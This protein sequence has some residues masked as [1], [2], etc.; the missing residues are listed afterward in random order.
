MTRYGM[1]LIQERTA[2]V[3]RLQKT[4]EG[5]NIK[6]ASVAS[7]VLGNSGREMREGL[8]GGTTE[9]TA[10]AELAKGKLRKKL[11]ELQRAL[12]GRF[13]PHQRFLLGLHLARIA[14]LDEV[15]A[16]LDAE[17]AERLH[18][19]AEEIARLDA[20]PSVAWRTA[21]V[22]LAE[23]GGDVSR[24]PT[25]AHLAS[26]A[27]VCPGDIESAGKRLSGRTRKGN[28]YLREALAEAA[29]AAARR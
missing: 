4:L 23:V 15:I 26:W 8:V 11:P 2:E 20:I 27:G 10:L 5:A 18:P 12:A 25:A 7:N 6:L 3:N 29:Q 13:G 24:F 14:D 21:E 19:H 16:H 17:I 1:A 28:R 22:I 9:P